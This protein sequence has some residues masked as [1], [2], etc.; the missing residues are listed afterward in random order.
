MDLLQFHFILPVWLS[1]V[2]IG[3]WC[4]HHAGV[5]LTLGLKTISR[6]EISNRKHCWSRASNT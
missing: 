3:R 4:G 6:P 5:L 2:A 1:F